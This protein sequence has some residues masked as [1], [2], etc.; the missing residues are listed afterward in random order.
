MKLLLESPLSIA[1]SLRIGPNLG[2]KSRVATDCNW[3]L[4]ITLQMMCGKLR[5]LSP[6]FGVTQLT[7]MLMPMAMAVAYGCVL[8]HSTIALSRITA[9]TFFVL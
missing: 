8:Q 3:R 1:C 7:R 2:L 5:R 4:V 6:P 9:L